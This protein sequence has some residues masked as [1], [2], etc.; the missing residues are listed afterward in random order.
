MLVTQYGYLRRYY[1]LICAVV[2]L[3]YFRVNYQDSISASASALGIRM[4]VRVTGLA[5]SKKFRNFALPPLVLFVIHVSLLLKV[6][7]TE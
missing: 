6:I 2:I 4:T 7:L 3:Q 5:E 1:Y